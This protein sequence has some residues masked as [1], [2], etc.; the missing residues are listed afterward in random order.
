MKPEAKR[1]DQDRENLRL[2]AERRTRRAEKRAENIR[3]AEAGKRK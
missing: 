1:T 3:K 2:A